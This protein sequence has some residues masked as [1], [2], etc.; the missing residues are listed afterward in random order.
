M[1]AMM[2]KLARV[3]TSVLEVAYEDDGP[4]DA[5]PVLLLHGYPYDTRAFDEVVPIIIAAGYRTIVP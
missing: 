4:A 3:R 5:L 1:E 2:A